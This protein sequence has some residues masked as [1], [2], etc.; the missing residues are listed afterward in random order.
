[1]KKFL[2]GFFVLVLLVI[3]PVLA[4]AE[5]AKSELSELPKTGD[6]KSVKIGA[7]GDKGWDTARV[8]FENRWSKDTYSIDLTKRGKYSNFID[9]PVGSY[10]VI[11][12]LDEN[13]E[14]PFIIK[15]GYFDVTSDT[16]Q[17]ILIDITHN[18]QDGTFVILLKNILFFITVLSILI[19]A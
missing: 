3:T 1:M 7:T 2:A 13:G 10:K 16:K 18:K 14:S 17:S 12:V 4:M 11:D 19:A 5:T 8:V 6:I 9:L 15:D